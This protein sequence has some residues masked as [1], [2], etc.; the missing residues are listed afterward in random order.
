[1]SSKTQIYKCEICGSMV[2]VI[3]GGA[4]TL[5]CCNTPMNLQSENTTEAAT[6][7]HIPVISSI[8]GGFEVSVGSVIHP[9][10]EKHYIE[11]I[12]LIADGE[13]QIKYFKPGET[14]VTK[15][16][17]ESTNV[18]VRAFCNLHGL[19]SSK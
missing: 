8:E 15:F 4:G 16:Y 2:N 5:E 10:E 1:M 6:E 9:M 17:V 19:W 12:E 14:P 3:N 11:W 18:R 7:K 13:S